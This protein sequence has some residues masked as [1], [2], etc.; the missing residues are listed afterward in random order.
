LKRDPEVQAAVE[1]LKD[2]PKYKKIL[3]GM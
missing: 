1:L 3:T 2:Q